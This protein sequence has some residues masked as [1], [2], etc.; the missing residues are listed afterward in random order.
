MRS[1]FEATGDLR[2][3]GSYSYPLFAAISDEEGG[4]GSSLQRQVPHVS[5]LTKQ[6]HEGS[7]R[8]RILVAWGQTDNIMD[9]EFKQLSCSKRPAPV[10][11]SQSSNPHHQP[12]RD[13]K[14]DVCR[15][16]CH[17][18]FY[19]D[20][21]PQ[22]GIVSLLNEQH[23][24]QPP[25]FGVVSQEHI[26]LHISNNGPPPSTLVTPILANNQANLAG[27]DKEIATFAFSTGSAYV[28]CC[29][30]MVHQH[31]YLQL[32]NGQAVGLTVIGNAPPAY[33][34]VV[35]KKGLG[36]GRY[37][38]VANGRVAVLF[39]FAQSIYY[40]MIQGNILVEAGASKLPGELSYEKFSG[41][42]MSSDGAYIA[43][44]STACDKIFLWQWHWQIMGSQE[45]QINPKV[46]DLKG[47]CAIKF[48]MRNDRLLA[49][50]KKRWA[51]CQGMWISYSYISK[52]V[53]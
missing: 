30:R 29:P 25:H 45:E 38:A 52:L 3:Q 50:G 35:W 42:V 37:L 1:K 11:Q 33:Q 49:I 51:Y 27:N 22:Q 14:L 10:D 6:V 46:F 16:G 40:Y 26:H 15:D 41:L 19:Q 48:N 53:I 32:L 28:V 23:P 4:A 31:G 12:G 18:A 34:H 17:G 44:C 47:V 5:S 8:Y 39:G 21:G 9:V 24:L 36:A 13:F 43:M 2:L 20:G 7:E